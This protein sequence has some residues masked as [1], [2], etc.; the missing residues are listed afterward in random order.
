MKAPTNNNRASLGMNTWK[1][2]FP[3][4]LKEYAKRCRESY[5]SMQNL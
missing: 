1:V 5:Y 3:K 2:N 4:L